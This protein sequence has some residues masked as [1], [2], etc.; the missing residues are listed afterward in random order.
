MNISKENIDELNAVLKVKVE[1]NDYNS[2]VEEVLKDYKKKIRLDGFRPGKVPFG[3]V[4]KMYYKQILVEEVNKSLSES[5]SKYMF[6]EKLRILGEPLPSEKGNDPINWDTQTD[7]DFSFDIG[8]APE[9]E[10]ALTKR[11]KIPYYI[12]KID[13]E[14]SN[15]YTE[16][17]TRRFGSN[18]QSEKVETG[19]ELL[20]GEI[21]QISGEDPSEEIVYSDKA[22]FSLSVMKDESIKK[23]F[24][25]AKIGDHI[26]FDMKKAFPNETEIASILQIDKEKVSN[27]KDEFDFR[28]NE[29][30]AFVNAEIN[31]ELFD[32]AYGKD[33]IKSEEEFRKEIEKDIKANLNKESEMRFIVDAKDKLVKKMKLDLPVEFLNRWLIKTNE[34]K[35]TK[36][37]IEKD[38]DHFREDLEWQLIRDELI[39]KHNIEVKEEDVLQYAKEV[40]MMQFMQYGLANI[41]DDQLEHYA[42]ELLGKEEERKKLTEK[43]YED[44]VVDYIKGVVKVDE[45]EV[46]ADEFNKLYVK[47]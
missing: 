17:F 13:E 20:T 9:F 1:K 31:Q 26:S 16:N 32:K 46:S 44:K 4:K 47:K 28:I 25:G 36:E 19:E 3:L 42:K 15:S 30:S 29:I 18:K 8:L 7:F 33:K 38:F 40:T 45:K 21:K 41:P 6:D 35:F 24:I 22:N 37:E 11:D 43:L 23:K 27:L 2:K 34:G 39:Q 5:L 14:I 12:I 10:V